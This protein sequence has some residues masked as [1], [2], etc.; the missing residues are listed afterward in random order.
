[1][2]SPD[3]DHPRH[4]FSGQ[5]R[6]PVWAGRDLHRGGTWLG[7]NAAGLLAAVTNRPE[8]TVDATRRSRGLLCLDV[9]QS[10][11]P[12]AAR[13]RFVDAL[14]ADSYN[15]FNLLCV[16]HREGWVGTWH[17]DIRDLTP[18][19]HVLSN[20]GDMDDDRLPVVQAVR[21][22]L[23]AEDVTAPRIDDLLGTLGRVCARS[24]G[25]VPLCRADGERGT[26]SASLVAVTADGSIAAYWYAPGPPSQSPFTPVMLSPDARETKRACNH[27]R[28]G[29]MTTGPECVIRVPADLWDA[30][31]PRL[32]DAPPKP[33]G[34][35]WWSAHPGSRCPQ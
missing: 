18:G 29:E 32:S 5:A 23:E 15:P 8:A 2:R 35:L 14:A 25:G 6:P 17:G 4:R 33:N 30:R 9:L 13:A 21:A 3:P 19:I 10:D 27:R 34:G 20:H 12:R 1:M 28:G 16:N 26:V 7:I 24:D 31:D 11:S 22:S